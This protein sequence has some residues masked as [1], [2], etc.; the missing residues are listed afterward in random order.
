[1]L[2]LPRQAG[3][4]RQQVT[5]EALADELRDEAEDHDRHVA[6]RLQLQLHHAGDLAADPGDPWL[7]SWPGEL[8]TSWSGAV[9]SR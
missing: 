9:I 1:M 7:D 2:G 6:A 3:A 5:A 4:H 8:R